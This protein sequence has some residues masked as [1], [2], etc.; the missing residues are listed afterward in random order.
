LKKIA[1]IRE[2]LKK[3]QK[4]V[5]KRLNKGGFGGIIGTNRNE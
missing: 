5:K 4:K 1:E 3:M 2:F